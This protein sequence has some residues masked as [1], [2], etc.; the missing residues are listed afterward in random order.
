MFRNFCFVFIIL[1]IY[2]LRRIKKRKHRSDPFS[3]I[4]LQGNPLS[5]SLQ[6]SSLI[7]AT[8]KEII[9]KKEIAIQPLFFFSDLLP[10]Q[11]I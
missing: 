10:I 4:K 9:R 2:K 8:K 7:F 6:G 5:S 1:L 3:Y 11:D